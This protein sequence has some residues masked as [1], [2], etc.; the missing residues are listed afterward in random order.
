MQSCGVQKDYFGEEEEE[1]HDLT[2][3]GRGEWTTDGSSRDIYIDPDS[4]MHQDWLK[5]WCRAHWLSTFKRSLVYGNKL[6]Y[7]ACCNSFSRRAF[8]KVA[9]HPPLLSIGVL[10]IPGLRNATSHQDLYEWLLAIIAE[11][12]RQGQ[13]VFFPSLNRHHVD[14]DNEHDEAAGQE[15]D[16]ERLLSKRNDDLERELDKVKKTV[17]ELKKHNEQ[18]LLS[19]KSWFEKYEHLMDQGGSFITLIT[20]KKQRNFDVYDFPVD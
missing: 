11:S 5:K 8:T 13:R 2:S 15:T 14:R 6:S 1:R 7:H 19:S 12:T 20:P 10:Q 17:L 9:G 16:Q 4:K 3:S 18:L